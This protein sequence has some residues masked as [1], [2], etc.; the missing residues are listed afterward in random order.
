MNNGPSTSADKRVATRTSNNSSITKLDRIS[1]KRIM[2]SKS[3]STNNL[4]RESDDDA[5]IVAPLAKSNSM[6]NVS[7][8]Y[9][10][11]L[12]YD[13]DVYDSPSPYEMK[14]TLMIA[15][16]PYDPATS[17]PNVDAEVELS[18]NSGEIL[19]IYGGMDEDGFYAGKLNGIN[20]LVPSN[21][22]RVATEKEILK[23]FAATPIMDES[24]TVAKKKTSLFKKSKKIFSR[25][26]G[27]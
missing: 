23:G 17:S 4:S 22:V 20:G 21:F 14:P 7:S 12:D 25:L 9:F 18:F 19:E 5:F 24:N 13:Q 16:F 1:S 10:D 26:K 11:Q 8:E 2:T 3:S 6:P 27:K 15:L